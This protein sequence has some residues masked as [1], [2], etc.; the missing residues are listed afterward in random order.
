MKK[1]LII[2]LALAF[3]ALVGFGV[4]GGR[5]TP[6]KGGAPESDAERAELQRRLSSAITARCASESDAAAD[7]DAC[8][9]R[10]TTD[11]N[12]VMRLLNTHA[13]EPTAQKIDA[14]LAEFV[15]SINAAADWSAARACLEERA[16]L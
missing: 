9:R 15:P 1:A 11:L 2:L 16:G 7:R 6:V 10:Q 12:Q 14:C 3:I 13:D 5:Q 4:F 8:A